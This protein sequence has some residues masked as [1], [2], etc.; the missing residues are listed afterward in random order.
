MIVQIICFSIIPGAFQFEN[1]TYNLNAS[2]NGCALAVMALQ[3]DQDHFMDLYMANDFGEWIQPNELLIN[4]PTGFVSKS[5][6]Y[7][8]DVPLY[9]MGIA[10]GD[11]DQD[12]LQDFYVTNLGRNALMAN[13]MNRFQD[14]TTATGTED[15]IGLSGKL[16]TGWGT[17]FFDYDHDM[18]EDLFV[19]NGYVPAAEFLRNEKLDQNILFEQTQDGRFV[20]QATFGIESQN[21]NRGC[22]TFDFDHDGDL[23]IVVA[24]LEDF[25]TPNEN[26]LFY[27]NDLSSNNSWLQI[28][29]I[30]KTSNQDGY[31]TRIHCYSGGHHMVRQLYSGGTHA[32]QSS[33]VIH[34]GLQENCQIDSLIIIWPSGEK[35]RYFNI[36]SNQKIQLIESNTEVYHLFGE[37]I[38]CSTTSSYVYAEA[39]RFI[40]HPD[41]IE[42]QHEWSTPYQVRVV[43]QLGQIILQRT[44]TPAVGSISLSDI[45]PGIYYIYVLQGNQNFVEKIFL[46]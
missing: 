1:E 16:T 6:E 25:S 23:D 8:L 32:S 37:P 2:A 43:N 7:H 46:Q 19:S 27:R 41:A 24:S 21:I 28:E 18:D 30:G 17:F 29:L 4:S 35:Q 22:A 13:Q 33:K 38:H 9:G 14:I 15:V 40:A 36:E 11:C 5:A 10:L 45:H 44:L 39:P 3:F 20:K 42:I 12:G 26:V 31:G 34:F